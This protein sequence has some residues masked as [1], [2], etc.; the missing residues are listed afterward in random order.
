MVSSFWCSRKHN[1]IGLGMYRASENLMHFT[2]LEHSIMC[3]QQRRGQDKL[4]EST[5]LLYTEKSRVLEQ[6][7][8]LESVTSGALDGTTAIQH[9]ISIFASCSWRI[10]HRGVDMA[11]RKSRY[12]RRC[13]DAVEAWWIVTE[14]SR[15]MSLPTR[16]RRSE[17]I[18]MCRFL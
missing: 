17:A 5:V 6:P 2:N 3:Q 4:S 9:H 11:K 13:C 14:A 1:G 16:I 8:A 18:I 10:R 7:G 15:F 12:R